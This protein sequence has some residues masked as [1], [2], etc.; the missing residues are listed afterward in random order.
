MRVWW[1]LGAL[2]VLLIA[3]PLVVGALLPARHVARHQVVIN[4]DQST[5]F[6]RIMSVER[7]VDWRPDVTSVEVVSQDPFR[8]RESGSNG[9]ILFERTAVDAPRRVVTRIADE[10]LPFGGTWTFTLSATV[11]GTVVSIQEDGIV[12]NPLF[13]FVSRFVLG[14][15]ASMRTYLEALRAS[16]GVSE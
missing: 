10:N 9:V 12:R 3:S 16:V 15:E 13:R 2:V 14:H 5:V 7:Y 4:A 8:F 6:D 1:I 11:D